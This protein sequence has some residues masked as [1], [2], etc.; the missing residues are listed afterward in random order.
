MLE[1]II[2]GSEFFKQIF[3]I[4]EKGKQTIRSLYYQNILRYFLRDS[5]KY[6]KVRMVARSLINSVPIRHRK[7]TNTNES[8]S[9]IIENRGKTL[10]KYFDELTSWKLLESRRTKMEKGSGTTLEYRLTDFGHLIALVINIDYDTSKNKY[11]SLYQYLLAYFTHESYSLDEFCIRYL[12]KCK[13]ANLFEPFARNIKKNLI[14]YNEVIRNE[15][16]FFTYMILLRTGNIQTDAVL[17]KMWKKSLS[18]LNPN[19]RKHLYHNLKLKVESIIEQNARNYFEYERIRYAI[20]DMVGHIPVESYCA[21]CNDY[22]K[23]SYHPVPL[24]SYLASLF[25]DP[26]ILTD[27]LSTSMKCIVCNESRFSYTAI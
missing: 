4:D 11:D 26:E 8:A 13:A 16:D 19:H 23:C 14:Y 5:S 27:F 21:K 2:Y 25:Y 6:F 12:E 7:T 9:K 3:K 15:H 17:W 10:R 24:Q 18:E 22:T 1:T 20:R